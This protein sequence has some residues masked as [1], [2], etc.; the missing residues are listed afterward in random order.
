[1][2]TFIRNAAILGGLLLATAGFAQDKAN[3]PAVE[4]TNKAVQERQKMQ[5]EAPIVLSA[6]YMTQE[7]G[8]SNDQSE[9]LKSIEA[10][11]NKQSNELEMLDPEERDPKQER[12]MQKHEKMIDSILTPEQN[13][14]LAEIK[15]EI[16]KKNIKT[17]EPIAE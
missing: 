2:S 7:L 5:D 11:I 1:M 15:A 13:K 4:P 6:E 12:L 9:K 16:R 14:K 3:N 17:N 10:D 8:L